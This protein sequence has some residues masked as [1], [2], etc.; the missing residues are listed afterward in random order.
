MLEER[1]ARLVLVLPTD[2][3]L[4]GS[5]QTDRRKTEGEMYVIES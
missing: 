2:K 1:G 4:L 5:N 3:L